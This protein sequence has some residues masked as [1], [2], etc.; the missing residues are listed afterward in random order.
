MKGPKIGQSNFLAIMS[1]SR[2]M[3]LLELLI[4]MS[5]L[6][7]LGSVGARVLALAIQSWEY[8]E[9]QNEAMNEVSWA[10]DHLTQ[11]VRAANNLL[12]PFKTVGASSTHSVLAFSAMVDTDEDGLIDEDPG[13]DITNDQSP[14][15][16]LIDDDEDGLIDEGKSDDDDD[17]DAIFWWIFH[18]RV[19]EDS[20]NSLDDEL[21]GLVDE[22][23]NAD[24]SKDSRSGLA[25]KDDDGDGLVDEGNAADDDEDGDEFPGFIDEDPIEYWVYYLDPVNH[26][27]MERYYMQPAEILIEKVTTFKVQRVESANHLWPGIYITLGV[28][29]SQGEEVLFKTLI[30]LRGR[31]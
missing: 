25:Y 4:A 20:W 9:K 29:I 3:T 7:I 19:D 30:Y 17:E 11:R 15:I 18:W 28:T 12:L 10:L 26:R 5:I 31:P 14:G 24:L 8:N 13:A 23:P 27:L 16:L 6:A 22:D 2:G 21:D 1:S